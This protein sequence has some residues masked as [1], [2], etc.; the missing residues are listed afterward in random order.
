MSIPVLEQAKCRNTWLSSEKAV[1]KRISFVVSILLMSGASA[2][3]YEA[4]SFVSLSFTVM[5]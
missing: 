3:L 2:H 1:V 4:P 5:Q